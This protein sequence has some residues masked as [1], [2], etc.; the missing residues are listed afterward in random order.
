MKTSAKITTLAKRIKANQAKAITKPIAI[1]TSTI[2]AEES[3]LDWTG[4]ND[5]SNLRPE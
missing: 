3:V 1:P 2:N 5:I 4:F